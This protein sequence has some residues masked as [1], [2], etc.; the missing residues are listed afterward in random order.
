MKKGT[1]LLFALL[2]IGA[3]AAKAQSTEQDMDDKYAM[4]LVKAGTPAPDFKM[5]TPDGKMIQLSEFAKG[6][7]VVLDFWASWC[8]D[9]RKDAPEV[10]RLYETYR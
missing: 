9:C 4:E 6:K 5:E 10:V 7:T 1:L 8:P 2:I 3:M